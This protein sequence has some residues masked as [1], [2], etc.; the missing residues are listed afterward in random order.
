MPDID[1]VAAPTATSGHAG[2]EL[3]RLALAAGD[4]EGFLDRLVRVAVSSLGG[5]IS[6][7]VTVERAGHPITVASSDEG[8][9]RCD[10]I[11]YCLDDGPC[12]TAM[13]TGAVVLID[14]LASDR[15]F[16]EYRTL[17]LAAGVR[18]SLS[19]PL[20][21]GAHAVGALNLYSHRVRGFGPAEQ[22]EAQWFS[23]EAARALDLAV[24]LAHDTEVTAQLR[25]ALSS[26]TVIDQAI[27]ILMG[28]SRCDADAA[29]VMLRAASQNRNLKLRTVAVEIVT[30]VGR[31]PPSSGHCFEDGGPP[32][33]G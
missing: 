12:L 27:G 31:K 22:G 21:A 29:F 1:P 25:A 13:R 19:W 30:T 8:A 10:E 4:L 24:R 28:Q 17:A 32:V 33:S 14:D 11:Q 23:G 3:Q 5:D 16:A 2:S 15:R 9:A 20:A 7:A 6:A 26:R 18:S